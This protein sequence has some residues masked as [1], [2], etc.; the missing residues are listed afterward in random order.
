MRMLKLAVAAAAVLAL[1]ITSA[2]A[3]T[4]QK[5]REAPG[6][7]AEI[8]EI[9]GTFCAI[10][11]WHPAV[12]ECEETEEDDVVYRTLT[13]KD[14][15]KIKE[16]LTG[17][18]GTSYSYEIVEGPLPVKNYKSKFRIE[19]DDE[20]DRIAIYWKSEFDAADGAD[21]KDVKRT[22][23][24]ILNDG[25]TGVKKAALAHADRKEGKAVDDDNDDD[26]DD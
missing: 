14:G 4:V 22:V 6:T 5:R 2:F 13:L 26:D 18:D 11:S 23:T 9:V 10:E 3:L 24:G 19:A 21:E 8:W 17:T 12:A 7:P 20:E 15:A 16:K 25:V 1:G